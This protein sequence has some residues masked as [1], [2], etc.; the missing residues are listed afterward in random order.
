M[1]SMRQR[2]RHYYRPTD[3]EFKQLWGACIFSPDANT[4]LN[5]YRYDHRARTEFLGVLR[6]LEDR[7]WVTHQAADE[8]YRNRRGEIDAQLKRFDQVLQTV[9]SSLNPLR[10]LRDR[11]RTLIDIEAIAARLQPAVDAAASTLELQRA[12][13]PDYHRDDPLLATLEEIVGDKVGGPYDADALKK[14]HAAAEARFKQKIPPG[15][16][17]VAAKRDPF[18]D[19]VI[20]RQLIDYAVIGKRP[21]VFVTD[22]AKE[23]WWEGQKS[24]RIGPRVELREEMYREAGVDFYMYDSES[25]LTHAKE[26]GYNV[27]EST[28]REAA[29]V[30]R[31]QHYV[32]RSF[33]GRSAKELE[34]ARPFEI[35]EAAFVAARDLASDLGTVLRIEGSGTR[36]AFPSRGGAWVAWGFRCYDARV[37]ERFVHV[38][39]SRERDTMV[40]PK[41]RIAITGRP[42]WHDMS[43]DELAALIVDATPDLTVELLPR[44][45]GAFLVGFF[46]PQDSRIG[47]GESRPVN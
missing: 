42:D 35:A 5:V 19:Y 43:N 37:P 9:R 32:P 2:F 25:F 3:D 14:I 34:A 30:R 17:D 18:G 40:D 23:D 20:W 44:L 31:E 45:F 7:L 39:L 26:A 4:L 15:F 6:E 16:A 12:E 8:F 29:E 28:I 47:T 36:V 21:I 10:E 33:L 11:R 1:S 24:R 13:H 38:L 41:W 46:R 27:A 22:D